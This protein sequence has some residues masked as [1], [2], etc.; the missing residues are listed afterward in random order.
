MVGLKYNRDFPVD[1][2]MKTF[3]TSIKLIVEFHVDMLQQLHLPVD[4]IISKREK[5]PSKFKLKEKT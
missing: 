1:S 5:I 4:S 3:Y 2:Q